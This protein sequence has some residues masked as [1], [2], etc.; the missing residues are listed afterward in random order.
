MTEVSWI[1]F[2]AA[3]QEQ[4]AIW[5]VVS[6]KALFPSIFPPKKFVIS[7]VGKKF[8]HQHW[9]FPSMLHEGKGYL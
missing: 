6:E 1:L 9:N 8:D 4:S 3:D 7:Q 2:S 5:H